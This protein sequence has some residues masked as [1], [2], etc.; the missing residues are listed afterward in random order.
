VQPVLAVPPR[1]ARGRFEPARQRG[2]ELPL[3]LDEIDD[4]TCAGAGGVRARERGGRGEGVV[5]RCATVHR[6]AGRRSAAECE[7]AEHGG[8][9]RAGEQ[10][11]LRMPFHAHPRRD[12]E[13]SARASAPAQ[14]RRRVHTRRGSQRSTGAMSHPRRSARR[15]RSRSR[16]AR[17]PGQPA[18]RRAPGAVPPAIR[19]GEAIRRTP[20]R[21]STSVCSVRRTRRS[22]CSNHASGRGC[23]ASRPHTACSGPPR[24]PDLA[25]P[26]RRRTCA[27]RPAALRSEARVRQTPR[28]CRSRLARSPRRR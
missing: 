6:R 16:R 5:G 28:P 2:G 20:R 10:A 18:E 26:C 27:W 7:R 8:D 24:L 14:H 3:G 25:R 19:R 9:A 13:G 11:H 23:G 22:A 12:G 21:G 1:P 17:P 4:R 15:L